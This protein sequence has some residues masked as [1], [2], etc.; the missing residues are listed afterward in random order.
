MLIKDQP[1]NG[2][3]A[4]A[5]AGQH[6]QADRLD[7]AARLY[8]AALEK[9]PSGE[10]F[11]RLVEIHRRQGKF[12]AL[13]DVAGQV[14]QETGSLA[15]LGETGKTLAADAP[16]VSKVVEA[17]R[18]RIKDKAKPP[19]VEVLEAAALL[20]VDG[21][22]YDAAGEL[23]E[24]APAA[25]NAKPEKLLQAWGLALL[26]ANQHEGAAKIFRRMLE[27]K[28]LPA[29][30]ASVHFYLAGALTMLGQTD[31]ALA[32]AER[33]AEL[34]PDNSR[35]AVRVGWVLH[36]AKRLDAA[37]QVQLELLRKYDNRQADSAAR[38]IACEA[39]RALSNIDLERGDFAAAVEWLEQVLDEF[40]E[41]VGAGNDLGY[42]WAERGQHLQR[43]L[44]M[45][46][47]AVAAEPENGAY[48]DS[49]GWVLFQLGR[50][51]E[52]E[53][54]LAQA[55]AGDDPDGVILDHWADALAKLGRDQDARS[56]RQRAAQAFQKAGDT[57][58]LKVVEKKLAK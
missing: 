58:K 26:Q 11:R 47:R 28:K 8:A 56:A 49:L 27:E 10:A 13:L 17:I 44:R 40:P 33:A 42:L 52:A 32:C 53:K 51:A 16:A 29:G 23:F 22:Q 14:V 19:T 12:D 24:A 50:Y 1:D 45:I 46:Q 4:Q 21:K 2:A 37:R 34:D 6:F 41:D 54:A 20:A 35:F 31:E 18:A 39:R 36:H 43:S 38:R 15:V 5:L 57:D 9:R 7:D 25:A 55:A 3:L 48:R 30:E